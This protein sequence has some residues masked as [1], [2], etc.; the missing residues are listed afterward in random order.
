MGNS[1]LPVPKVNGIV[2]LCL[3]PAWL[4]Q[5]L[6]RLVHRGPTVN[7]ILPKLNNAKYLSLLYVISG[8]HNLKL[9]RKIIILMM[10]ACQIGKYSYKQLPFGAALAGDM[11]QR[12]SDEI[13]KDLPNVFG[14]VDDILV[15]GYE[16]DCKD[17]DITVW[18]VLQRCRQ[19][20]LKLNKR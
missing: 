16:A 19:V 13:V 15:T 6:I 2:R 10:F 11:F 5:A 14:I 3:D 20:T 17:L 8:Y 7:D 4:N 12:K 1:C 18:K 9:D